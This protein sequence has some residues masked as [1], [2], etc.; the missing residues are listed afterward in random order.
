[1]NLNATLFAQ[2]VVFFILAW[3]TMQFVWPPI[4]KALDE[5]AKKIADGLAAA[6]RGKHDLELATKRSTEALR[7]GKEKA[8]ELLAQAEKRAAQVIEEAKATAKTEADRIVAGAKAEIDQE[9]VRAKE[10]L[11]EQVSAL[12]VSGAEK[13]LRREINAQAHADIL[14]TIKQDL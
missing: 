13:I 11:R 6:E 14:A 8:A 3:F 1:M 7:E 2:L 4:V 9:A 5:R 10:Q 12:V